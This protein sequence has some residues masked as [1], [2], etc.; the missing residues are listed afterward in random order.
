MP[1]KAR[2][3]E[4]REKPAHRP[5]LSLVPKQPEE[6]RAWVIEHQTTYEWDLLHVVIGT[7]KDAEEKASELDGYVVWPGV[8]FTIA[9]KP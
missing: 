6:I 2:L 4:F 7:Q 9:I 1:P 8:N 5:R 3:T